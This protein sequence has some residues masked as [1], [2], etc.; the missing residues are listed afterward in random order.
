MNSLNT[1]A[2]ALL[3]LE[4]ESWATAHNNFE[5]LKNV[6]V[7]S[8]DF[9]G[10]SVE[11]HFNQSRM[12]SAAAKLD[13]N[14][15]IERK[16]FL[17]SKNRPAEQHSTDCEYFELLV[18][19]YPIFPQHF[20]IAS[21][22]HEPQNIESY[23]PDFLNFTKQL[24]D[25][26]V[27]FNAAGCGASA[28]DHLHFQ[29]GTKNFLPLI[30]DYKNLK[31]KNAKLF[32]STND[33]EIFLLEN[34]LRKVFCI[35]TANAESARQA[36]DFMINTNMIDTNK[37]NLVAT[38]ENDKFFIFIFPRH[39]FRPRQFFAENEQE[40]LLISPGSVEMSGIL[41]TPIKAHFDK[42]T[43]TDVISIYEQVGG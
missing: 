27:F 35:E 30:K 36:F 33:Y 15:I 18:N 41:I 28:P 6:E 21:K 14:S 24:S 20:T 7:K 2:L 17:C 1:K 11:I 39:T 12:L 42:I 29:A 5:N 26:V 9:D 4:L 38:F 10:F 8:L 23:F 16:C 22:Q 32:F 25:F 19:P 31:Q 3:Q 37:M 13:A 34:Y 43:K 40:R